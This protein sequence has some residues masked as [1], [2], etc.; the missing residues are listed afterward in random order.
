MKSGLAPKI[1]ALAMVVCAILVCPAAFAVV[2]D[3]QQ[4]KDDLPKISEGEQKA[5]EKINAASGV[6]EKLKAAAEYVKKNSKSQMR[7]RIAAYVSDQIAK[8]TDHNQRIG[9]VENFTKTFNLPEEADLIKP[10]LIDSLIGSNKFEEAFNEGS[11]HLEKKPDDVI[12]LTQVAWAGAN[13]ARAQQQPNQ[14]PPAALLKN[15]SAAG[16]KAV[17]MLE[18][19]KKPEGMD[20]AFWG[21]FRNSWLP[22]LYQA[23]GV[24]LYFSD[25]KTGAKD[26]LEKAAGLD[27]YDPPTLLMLSDILNTEYTKLGERYQAERKQ[28]LLNEAL[29]KMDELIDWLARAAAATEG[30]AQ[31]EKLNKDIMDQ[32]KNYYSYRHE[33]KADG[34]TELVK[35][36]KKP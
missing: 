3:K 5:I 9:F 12:V 29:Q 31:Y 10:T 22:R 24:I 35:K 25:D 15:A 2:Q 30:N 8:V 7:P 16:A 11:K 19:D 14:P 28:A 21:N 33:G 17:E 36:Y 23:Q 20:A 6:A 26:K 18:A 4:S 13:Q 32:L 34:L 27:P 1:L